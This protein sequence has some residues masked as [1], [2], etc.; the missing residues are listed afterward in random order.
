FL[1]YLINPFTLSN[2]RLVM[3]DVYLTT[4]VVL[5]VWL[6]I[7]IS[8]NK[9]G[10]LHE[11]MLGVV[12][13]LAVLTK[14]IG[15]ISWCLPLIILFSLRFGQWDQLVRKDAVLRYSLPL[16]VV[17]LVA[18][19]VSIPAWL[20]WAASLGKAGVTIVNQVDLSGVWRNFTILV[21]WL[22]IYL[23]PGGAILA[24][25][26]TLFT[27]YM[28]PRRGV[29][30]ASWILLFTVSWVLV[31]RP[32]VL[33][34]TMLLPYTVTINMP[35]LVVDRIF[36][37][38]LILPAFPAIFILS[39]YG[40]EQFVDKF[41]VQKKIATPLIIIIMMLIAGPMLYFDYL[42]LTKPDI[43]PFPTSDRLQYVEGD[44][45]GYG[46]VELL[47][48]LHQQV[49]EKGDIYIATTDPVTR[50]IA[51]LKF[52]IWREAEQQIHIL[53]VRLGVKLTV[54]D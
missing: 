14:T 18:V 4:W 35:W 10:W 26:A 25:L 22:W 27:L 30:L 11:I 51:G 23:T 40:L 52:D 32:T 29:L 6:S 38:R 12:L 9:S 50:L 3:T 21:T 15:V 44:T 42:L 2:D 46:V 39:G 36:Y 47:E 48:V 13:G 24:T 37:P 1:F 45:S 8:Q 20:L 7:E 43:A 5:I 41:A 19:F 34:A 28:T 33:A 54:D 31:L 16:I 49:E 53:N 17:Y